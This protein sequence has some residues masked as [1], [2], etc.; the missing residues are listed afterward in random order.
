MEKDIVKE[1]Q[2]ILNEMRN[3][4]EIF[5]KSMKKLDYKQKLASDKSKIITEMDKEK[6]RHK[7]KM[8][9]LKSSIHQLQKNIL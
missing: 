4:E 8:D 6:K 9:T 2:Y 1:A 3:E 7:E 5:L